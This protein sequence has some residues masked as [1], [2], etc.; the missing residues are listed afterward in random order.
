MTFDSNVDFVDRNTG[1]VISGGDLL[2]T[3][4]A[5]RSWS[6]AGSIPDGAQFWI[7][8]IDASTGFTS[9]RVCEGRGACAAKLWR[10]V[11]GGSTWQE[12]LAVNDENA[13][14]TA[15]QFIDDQR[16]FAALNTGIAATGNGGV[17]WEQHAAP[18]GWHL[19]GLAVADA[20][21]LWAIFETIDYPF[22]LDL[23]HSKEPRH[24]PSKGTLLHARRFSERR[25]R[26]TRTT[27][28]QRRI[29]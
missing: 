23:R 28:N 4:D 3:T 6:R 27:T 14:V 5:G 21:N 18:T 2:R 29:I 15:V 26:R 25:S 19:Q 11:D 12:V 10:T 24:P 1:Y 22:S 20:A 7:R 16:G 13:Y 17:T 9:S 8:F